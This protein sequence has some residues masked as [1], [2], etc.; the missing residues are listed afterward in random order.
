M[1][2]VFYQKTNTLLQ[3]TKIPTSS[4][5]NYDDTLN[6]PFSVNSIQLYTL[7]NAIYEYEQWY[8]DAYQT[9]VAE[10]NPEG[11]VVPNSNLKVVSD[12]DNPAKNNSEI[13]G[14]FTMQPNDV[15]IVKITPVKASLKGQAY[16]FFNGSGKYTPDISYSYAFNDATTPTKITDVSDPSTIT[17][18]SGAKTLQLDQTGYIDPQWTGG[19]SNVKIDSNGKITGLDNPAE[20]GKTVTFKVTHGIDS[21]ITHTFNVKIPAKSNPTPTP[22]NNGA[23]S[24]N[25]S[26]APANPTNNAWNPT[27]PPKAD[28]ST[29]LPNYAAVKG[30]AV[31]ATKRVYMYRNANFKKSQ[32]IATYPKAKRV[33]RPMFVVLDYAKSNGGAL[34]YKVRDV[35]HNSKTDGKIG[36]ITANPKYVVNVYYKTM[37]KSHKIT[38]INK[39]GIHTYKH[40][41]LTGRVKTFKKGTHITVKRFV[42]HNLTTRYQLS[43]GTYITANKKLVIQ[44]NY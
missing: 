38:V 25:N 10:Y 16:F 36:Y 17:A 13:A 42:K 30:A 20:A 15:A 23:S 18:P 14:I 26:T 28:G 31:Y 44:G 37:P 12:T 21:T 32:R 33:N 7:N 29:G 43:N 4:V 35:N 34:R 8:S 19:D 2:N 5:S 22:N 9:E 11:K 3:P 24:S 40:V 6:Q 41:N 39:K 1:T 27:T